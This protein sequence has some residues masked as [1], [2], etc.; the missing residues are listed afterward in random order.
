MNRFFVNE[1]AKRTS[2]DFS[3]PTP[4][5]TPFHQSMPGYEPAPLV[6]AAELARR[7][8]VAELLIKD[9]AHCLGLPAFKIMGASWAVNCAISDRLGLPPASTFAKL[10]ERA[11]SLRHLKLVTATDGNHGRAVAH[12]AALLHLGAV[13]YVPSGTTRVR[14]Q[15]IA[16]EGARV[17][18]VQGTYDDA[19]ARV[20]QEADESCII[21][22]DTSWPGYEKTPRAVIDGYSTILHEIDEQ[23]DRLGAAQPDTVLVQCGVG[24]FAAAVGMHYQSEA[25]PSL[26]AVEPSDAACMMEALAA[27]KIVSVRGPHRSIMAGLN[28]GTLSLVAWPILA[29]TF[30]LCLTVDDAQARE[31]MRLLADAGVESGESGSAG[32]AGLLALR[33]TPELSGLRKRFRIGASSNVLVFSTEGAT[34]LEAYAQ[35]VDHR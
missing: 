9:L 16:Q 34:D 6:R 14:S 13:I 25:R 3:R 15:A 5:P 20:A 21:V 22:S 30:D 35:I 12:M 23:L 17:E 27:G 4:N 33:S 2:N 31:A 7:L 8:G 18:T 29:S 26:I 19:V 11:R 10:L 32:L 1:A 28:C 24:A